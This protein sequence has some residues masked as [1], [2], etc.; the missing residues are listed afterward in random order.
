MLAAGEGLGCRAAS[1]E[2]AR[3]W[4]ARQSGSEVSGFV[5]GHGWLWRQGVSVGC[6]FGFGVAWFCGRLPC[7][8]DGLGWRGCWHIVV[9]R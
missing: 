5:R 3:V 9:G 6:G 1:H 7:H 4:V 8:R 2:L